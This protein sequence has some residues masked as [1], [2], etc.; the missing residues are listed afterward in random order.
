MSTTTVAATRD[1]RSAFRLIRSELTKI[2]TTNTWWFLA[3]GALGWTLLSLAFNMWF[4]HSAFSNP[5]MFGGEEAGGFTSPEFHAG[6][7]YTSGQY[8]GL[9]FV[10]LIGILMVTNEFFH[11]TATVT[12]L[13]TP[14]RT[15]VIANKLIAAVLIGV[16]FWAVTTLLN[17]GPVAYFLNAEDLGTMLGDGSVRRTILL[18]LVAYAVW[19]IFGVAIGTLIRSQLAA[20]VISTVLYVIGTQVAGLI[21]TLLAIWLE[22]ESVAEWQVIIPSVASQVMTTGGEDIPGTPEWWVGALILLGYAVVA[23]V[24]GVLITRRRD[25]S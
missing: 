6:N 3:L 9:L 16:V 11:Q 13:T 18:N 15:V 10:M 4:A 5:E 21:F 2:R 12:F 17:L 19:S 1:G 25:I 24:A 23:G 7:L 20:T 22:N 14:H 8:L